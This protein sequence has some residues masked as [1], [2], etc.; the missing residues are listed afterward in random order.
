MRQKMSVRCLTALSV[1]VV[2]L[3]SV[4][5]AQPATDRSGFWLS[6]GLGA[7]YHDHFGT[8]AY[9]VGYDI[10]LG[11]GNLYLTP[12][13][14]ALLQSTDGDTGDPEASLLLTVGIGF[15]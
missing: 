9:L 11:G 8:A 10:R 7:G 15:R 12:N 3:P 4:G 13:L 1:L 6:G 2:A 5:G 14:D